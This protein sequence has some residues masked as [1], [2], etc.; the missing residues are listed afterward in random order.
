MVYTCFQMVHDCHNNQPEGWRYFAAQYIPLMR[1]LLSHYSPSATGQ[2]DTLR[3]VLQSLREPSSPLFQPLDQTGE[4]FFVAQLRQAVV[5]R[6]E[7]PPAEIP[8][9][10]ATVADALQPLTVV[11]K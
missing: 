11:E 2:E 10:L 8:L 7:I 6:I 3:R 4:R 1:R 9:D 5:A